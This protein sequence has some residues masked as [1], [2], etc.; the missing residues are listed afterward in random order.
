[1]THKTPVHHTVDKY[2]KKDGTIVRMH[3]RGKGSR[4]VNRKSSLDLGSKPNPT[5]MSSRLAGEW[6]TYPDYKY[7]IKNAGI[8]R[9][10][11]LGGTDR[12]AEIILWEK[13]TAK[14]KSE[15]AARPIRDSLWPPSDD[16]DFKEF[17]TVNFMHYANALEEYLYLHTSSD[18][19]DLA[20]RNA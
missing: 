10:E 11:L 1:M 19:L 16:G 7:K 14:D 2:V 8:Y 12:G 4:T 17:T 13:R 20:V 3:Q 6:P 5:P 18:A 15:A 9:V